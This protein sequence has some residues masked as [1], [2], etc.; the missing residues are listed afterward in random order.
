MSLSPVEGLALAEIESGGEGDAP[1]SRGIVGRS[2][3]QLALARLRR[4]RTARVSAAL[5][6]F[7]VVVALVAPLLSMVYG[8]GPGEDFKDKLDQCCGMPLGYLGGIS[9]EHWFGLEPGT[10]RDIF[11]R[12]VYGL[13]TSLLI[14]FSAAVL[15]TA[16]GMTLGVVAGYLGGWIDAVITWITDLV[17]AMPF[18]II[19][20]AL[21]PT[22]VLRFYGER[23]A[24]PEAF[25]VAML[26]AIFVV[27]GWTST[28]RLVRGQVIA[29]REREFVEAARAS[30]AGLGHM[31]FRQLLPNI[32]API[33]VAF[34]LAVPQFITSEAALAFIGVG[35]TDETPSFGRMIYRSL[36]Y[37]QTDPAYVFFPGVTIFALVLA[38]NLFGDALRDALDPKSSR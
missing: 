5:L 12:M 3:G 26:I 19:A 28:A 14:A 36:D 27:F 23:D 32:W 16:L 18:L 35:L 8:V 2:P 29:L 17:L 24:V 7:F 15:S 22:L 21:M 9:G 31:L 38:F 11:I 6:V 4:D 25:G 1:R 34:S 13:R 30:G 20:L 10:G 33:L 37:L